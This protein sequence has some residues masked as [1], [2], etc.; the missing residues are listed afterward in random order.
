MY[1]RGCGYDLRKL[2]T[3]RCPEC[4][5]GFDPADHKTYHRSA[6]RYTIRRIIRSH[7]WKLT[8]TALILYTASYLLLVEAS[9]TI[10]KLSST[11]S[12]YSSILANSYVI[13]FSM[14]PPEPM[15]AEYRWGGEIVGSLFSPANWIDRHVR[16]DMWFIYPASIDG[17]KVWELASK[18]KNH[19]KYNLWDKLFAGLDQQRDMALPG[20][21][22]EREVIAQMHVLIDEMKAA[23]NKGK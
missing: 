9:Q 17:I 14:G 16:P 19:P 4:G 23:A 5:R 12:Q 22:E 2:D 21:Q 3:T 8:L 6:R 11:S 18:L 7:L 15:T 20:S 13:P 10:F 1:C